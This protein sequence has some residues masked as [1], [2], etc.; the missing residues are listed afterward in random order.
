MSALNRLS[1]WLFDLTYAPMAGLPPW[2]SLGVISAVIGVVMLLAYK[3]TSWQSQIGKARDEIKARMLAMKLFKDNLGVTL[4]AQ[5]GVIWSSFKILLLSIPPILVAMIPMVPLLA[6]LA[7]RYQFAPLPTSAVSEVKVALSDA[8]AEKEQHGEAEVALEASDGV[9][10]LDRWR[11][12]DSRQVWWRVRADR[13]GMH[14]LTVRAG[15]QTFTKQLPVGE[16]GSI[17]AAISPKLTNHYTGMLDNTMML[18]REPAPPAD[19][20]VRSIEV[21]GLMTSVAPDVLPIPILG[22][23]IVYFLIVSILFALLFKPLFNVRI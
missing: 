12:G 22:N 7:G 17:P 18:P 5:G 4:S 19:A 3:Y 21:A 6:Q 8:F 16:P 15:D 2:A 14:T 11:S 9:V 13:P 1:N 10:V 20:P 23:W